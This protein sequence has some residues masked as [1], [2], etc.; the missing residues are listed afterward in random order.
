MSPTRT[1][2]DGA[3]RLAWQRRE[4]GRI[5]VSSGSKTIT[6]WRQATALL[7]TL[8]ERGELEVLRAIKAG[9]LTVKEVQSAE[10]S[11]AFGRGDALQL[12]ALRRPLWATVDAWQ[13]KGSG[14]TMGRYAT[15]FKKLKRLT[16]LPATATIA[17]L[18]KID[19]KALK[20]N[21]DFKSASDWNALRRAISRFLT[22]SLGDVYH[23]AR[24][25]VLAKIERAPSRPRRV[26]VT[27]AEFWQLIDAC[28]D[29]V[30]A[31]VVTL[32]VTGMR[33][34]E[35]QR[36]KR[37]HLHA[38]KD[39][40]VVLQVQGSK[41]EGSTA[42][43]RVAASLASW[44]TA[45]VPMPLKPLWFRRQFKKGAKAIGRPE[46]RLHDLRHCTAMFALEGGAGIHAVRDLMRHEGAAQT[47][48]YTRSGNLDVAS[49]AIGKALQ[50]PPKLRIAK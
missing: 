49:E 3:W 15:S 31:G 30:R 44:L 45:G 41:T 22:V 24:R 47:L 7:T 27:A 14:L 34:G 20:A 39:G 29:V 33:L 48:D 26:Q 50:Q 37:A 1:S 9:T 38:L 36:A 11:K 10:K 6:G 21:P 5:T 17:D 42:E 19:W 32:A 16:K 4:I 13:A 25:A 28:P 8:Y 40:S 46:L 2:P 12:L 35:Y 18:G 23:P 43:V